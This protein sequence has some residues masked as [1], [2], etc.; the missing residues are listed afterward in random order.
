MSTIPPLTEAEIQTIKADAAKRFDGRTR[1]ILLDEPIFTRV[2]MAPFDRPSYATF[3]DAEE[4]DSTTAHDGLLL[5]RSLHPGLAGI[6]KLRRDWPAAAASVAGDME[7]AAGLVGAAAAEIHLLD[8]ERLPIGLEKGRAQELVAEASGARLWALEIP[9]HGLGV[10]MVTPVA[11]IWRAAKTLDAD[12]RAKKK[13]IIAA[14]ED[15]V[16]PAV[17][18]SRQPL[19]VNGGGGALDE[20]PALY[21]WLWST[22]NRMGGEGVRLRSKSL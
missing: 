5:T 14:T 1:E 3:V 17:V 21:W 19:V 15:Y 13:G 16:L 10:V 8:L 18:W 9:E 12:A 4:R 11:Q 6:D 20:R 22:W 7:R 2:V